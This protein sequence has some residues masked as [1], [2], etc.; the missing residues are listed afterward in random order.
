MVKSIP[1]MFIDKYLVCPCSLKFKNHFFHLLQIFP[2]ISHFKYNSDMVLI[3]QM[4]FYI[5]LSHPNLFL[6][7]YQIEIACIQFFIVS[8]C[9][10][11]NFLLSK[12]LT[13]MLN[14]YYI[15]LLLKANVHLLILI[16][17]LFNRV[18]CPFQNI[19]QII[20]TKQIRSIIFESLNRFNNLVTQLSN[21]NINPMKMVICWVNKEL[22]VFINIVF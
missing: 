9:F 5:V 16:G 7:V 1:Y 2:P 11:I 10:I 8:L 3:I 13:L 21:K 19:F 12:L 14:H 6:K 20:N 18:L 22:E 15:L 17:S 4:I